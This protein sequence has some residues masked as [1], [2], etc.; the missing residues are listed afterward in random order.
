MIL[1]DSSLIVAYSNKAD[2]NHGVSCDI[3]RRIDGGEFGTPVTTDYVF[4][5]SVTVMLARTGSL[6]RSR[7]LGELLLASTYMIRIG[8]EA[9]GLAWKRFSNQ[10]RGKLSFTDCTSIA[11]CKQGGIPNIGT[12]DEGFRSV[13]GLNVVRE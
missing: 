8:P 1:L 4:D 5:E 3:V 6:L 7:R 12:F 13:E 2:Q 10:G 11:V 9:F